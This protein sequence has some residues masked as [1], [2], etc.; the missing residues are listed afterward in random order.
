MLPKLDKDLHGIELHLVP[1][2]TYKTDE[3]MAARLKHVAIKHSQISS[4]IKTCEIEGINNV[5]NPISSG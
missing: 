4:N 2:L 1:I 5:D 3:N